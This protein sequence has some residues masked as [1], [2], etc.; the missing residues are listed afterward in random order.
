MEETKKA[1][2]PTEEIVI[3]SQDSAIAPEKQQ[4]TVSTELTASQQ[5]ITVSLTKAQAVMMRS[6][7]D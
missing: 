1:I 2:V 6:A 5:T 3:E 7:F 4:E